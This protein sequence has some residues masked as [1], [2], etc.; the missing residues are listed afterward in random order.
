MAAFR[1]AVEAGY[2]YLET[3][4]HLS[5]DGE[6]VV[7]HDRRLDRVTDRQGLIADLPWTQ[8]RDA[9]VGG[10]EPI[11]L[12]SE[13]LEEFPDVRFNIDAKSDAAVGPLAE[14]IRTTNSLHRVCLGS[15]IDQRLV[16]LR[17]LLGPEVTTSMGSREIFRM[18]RASALRRPVRTPAKAAQVPVSFRRVPIVTPRFLAAA[19]SA[20]VEVHVWTINDPAEMRR[21]LTLGVDGIMTDRPDL[22]RDVLQERGSWEQ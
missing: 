18:V 14:L 19:R 17:G 8:I 22:L 12:L 2:R 11:P 4:V 15:F 1:R 16:Q 3:D 5:A 10:T 21:L 9:R 7:F 20:G 13:L 6:L